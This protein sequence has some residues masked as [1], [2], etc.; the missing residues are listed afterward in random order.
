MRLGVE[1]NNSQSFISSI[2]KIWQQRGCEGVINSPTILEMKQL[3]I[4]NIDY[5]TFVTLQNGNLISI[6]GLD[7]DENDTV[8]YEKLKQSE[9]Y[10]KLQ[11]D[12]PAKIKFFK[13]IVSAYG[14][15][16]KFLN[17]PSVIIDH[18]YLWDLICKPNDKLFKEG[19]NMIILDIPNDDMTDKIDILCPSNSYS[20]NFFD[21][22]KD[23]IMLIRKKEGDREVESDRVVED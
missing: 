16:I 12:D 10:K 9:I 8:E 2:A 15:F 5:D 21:K 1:S 19:L 3:M 11:S 18:T 14:N 23:T 6:F 17:N 22:N 20:D 7:T 4:D 13:K